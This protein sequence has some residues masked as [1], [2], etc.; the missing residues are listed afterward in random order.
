MYCEHCV[1][2][3]VWLLQETQA[4]L[5]CCCVRPQGSL[6]GSLTVDYVHGNAVMAFNVTKQQLSEGCLCRV[7]VADSCWNERGHSR[8]QCGALWVQHHGISHTLLLR[9]RQFTKGNS[10]V[11]CVWA[12]FQYT[13]GVYLVG[14]VN[15]SSSTVVTLPRMVS[16]SGWRSK[17]TSLTYCSY[18]IRT[19]FTS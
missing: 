18:T 12:K 17:W 1:T 4:W 7:R 3:R 15:W 6:G 13:G 5:C 16:L 10:V 9:V 11:H 19:V 14:K 8:E 2:C